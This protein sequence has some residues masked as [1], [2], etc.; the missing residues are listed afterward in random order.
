MSM[1]SDIIKVV[2]PVARIVGPQ[3]WLGP[4]GITNIPKYRDYPYNYVFVQ[5]PIQKGP[6]LV[7]A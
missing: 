5:G 7:E 3:S 6:Y 4:H 1:P 2:E